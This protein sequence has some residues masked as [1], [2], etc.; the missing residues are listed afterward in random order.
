MKFEKPC[1][2]E[3]KLFVRTCGYDWVDAESFWHYWEA[4]DWLMT[5]KIKMKNWKNA[6]HLWAKTTQPKTQM[7]AL[8]RFEKE[9]LI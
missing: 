2:D 1:V 3:I 6:V 9:G 5:P 4:R 7:S 8:E